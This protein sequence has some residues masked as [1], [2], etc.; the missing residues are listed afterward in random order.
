ME[1]YSALVDYQAQCA[2]F[3]C[4]GLT[5]PISSGF[6]VTNVQ[7][8]QTTRQQN[9]LS[10]VCKLVYCPDTVLPR[11]RRKLRI[12]WIKPAQKGLKLCYT[13]KAS[14]ARDPA[15][16]KYCWTVSQDVLLQVVCNV[17]WSYLWSAGL[18]PREYSF[19]HKSCPVS[20]ASLFP[21]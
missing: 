20:D 8:W 1:V 19:G 11:C 17:T 5:C 10:S 3:E 21:Q 7:L 13:C 12:V 4:V 2:C 9:W 15:Q 6:Y 16:S 14:H 18:L